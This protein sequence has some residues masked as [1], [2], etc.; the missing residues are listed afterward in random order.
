MRLLLLLFAAFLVACPTRGSSGRRGDDDDD[1]D[2]AL[3]DDDTGSDDDD[4]TGDD[5]DTVGDDDDTVGDDDDSTPVVYGPGDVLVTEIMCNPAAVDDAAGEWIELYNATSAPINLSGWML[6]DRDLTDSV[7]ISPDA[8]LM[9]G[10]GQYLVL[11]ASTSTATNGGAPVAW[12]YGTGFEL[13]N[14]TD[15]V[16]LFA[17]SGVEVFGLE[18][19]DSFPNPAGVSTQYPGFSFP[20]IQNPA[21]W[22]SSSSGSYGLGDIGTPGAANGGC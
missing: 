8:P 11:G 6:E 3:D 19:T 13:A 21:N 1:D 10:A 18:Y 5:D 16:V 22:C 15:E 9:L 17:P 20:A 14:G 7:E 12:G 4:T 2:S